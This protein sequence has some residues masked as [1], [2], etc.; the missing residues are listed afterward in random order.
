MLLTMVAFMLSGNPV[1][2][3]IMWLSFGAQAYSISKEDQQIAKNM[4]Q[5]QFLGRMLTGLSQVDSLRE[6]GFLA[7]F[8]R[9]IDDPN[10]TPKFGKETVDCNCDFVPDN[11]QEGGDP[12]DDNGNGNY[13]EQ[14]PA[15]VYWFAD[16]A[17]GFRKAV[18]LIK[19][20]VIDYY[21]FYSA[22]DP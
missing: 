16:R 21:I 2:A 9:T 20:E 1:M 13:T 15:S 19:N 14:I 7:A 3:F 6:N 4:A 10:K 12:C 11:P 8:S 22:P 17:R 5:W 18:G